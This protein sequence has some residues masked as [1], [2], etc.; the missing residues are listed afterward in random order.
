MSKAT[1][2]PQKN[3]MMVNKQV[4]C[5][6]RRAIDANKLVSFSKGSYQVGD[7]YGWRMK[8][9]QGPNGSYLLVEHFEPVPAPGIGLRLMYKVDKN[10]YLAYQRIK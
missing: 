7:K 1:E 8:T 2:Y 9:E 5:R 10:L 6:I 4:F 3:L